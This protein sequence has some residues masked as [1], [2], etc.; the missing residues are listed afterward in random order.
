MQAPDLAALLPKV[1][2]LAEAA[3]QAILPFYR[4]EPLQVE[5]KADASP[6][7]QADLASHRLILQGLQDLTP[8]IPVLSEE[9]GGIP[10]TQR[11]PWRRFWLVDP[12]DGTREFI[13]RND[14]FTVNIALVEAGIPIL[15]VVHAPAL[16]LTYRAAQG[17]GAY[18]GKE[19]IRA[20]P[21]AQA[22]LQV[23][24][25]RS[26][27]SPETE[28]FLEQ[29]RRRYSSLEVK[30]VGSALKF[31]LVA[32]GSA[33]LYP[34]FGPTLEWDTAAAHCIVEQ[35][36]GSVTDLK[37]DPLRY[38]K[39]DLHNPPFVAA[40]EGVAQLWQGLIP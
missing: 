30:S 7:T 32:E 17:L 33:H 5:L 40:A 14:Q 2:H 20:R 11:Q 13:G 10:Y 3:G 19:P 8:E 37:G 38:N 22:P 24:A 36:G 12:L 26:H 6:L 18:K 28:Q 9:S 23:V 4:Q 21:P 34:R 16:G 1:C 25:S 29:L 15:G 35:A 31:C 39:P 27:R